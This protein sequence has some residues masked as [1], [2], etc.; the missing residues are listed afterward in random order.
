MNNRTNSK[1]NS[2][3]NRRTQF[4][5][6]LYNFI[7]TTH[8]RTPILL[9]VP[10]FDVAQEMI[11][12]LYENGSWTTKKILQKKNFDRVCKIRAIMMPH[13][14]LQRIA[15]GRMQIAQVIFDNRVAVRMENCHVLILKFKLVS[16]FLEPVELN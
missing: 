14:L 1:R 15:P 2:H 5:K 11:G 13:C 4:T 3:V 9:I 8:T 12:P 10:K 6:L 16:Q 7:N